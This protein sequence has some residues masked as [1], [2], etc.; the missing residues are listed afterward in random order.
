MSDLYAGSSFISQ[1]VQEA[2]ALKSNLAGGNSFVGAQDVSGGNV[3]VATG[4]NFTINGVPI[5]GGGSWI[6]TATSDLNMASY[7]IIN[8]DKLKG[9]NNGVTDITLQSSINADS[10]QIKNMAMFNPF[11]T[12]PSAGQVLTAVDSLEVTWA[13]PSGGSGYP[14]CWVRHQTDDE[15]GQQAY[16]FNTTTLF[17]NAIEG[18][19]SRTDYILTSDQYDSRITIAE[20]GTYQVFYS[21]ACYGTGDSI[22]NFTNLSAVNNLS[23]PISVAASTGS[24]L[25]SQNY[26]TTTSVNQE[27]RLQTRVQFSESAPAYYGRR[28]TSLGNGLGYRFVEIILKRIS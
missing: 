11:L 18:D 26:F 13:T 4:Y 17:L 1:P 21:I 23:L 27:F 9:A 3:N 10:N 19:F 12:T 16:N 6:G 24:I 2:L 22:A 7:D 14:S 28:T 25:S 8:I 5:G 15:F 20:A